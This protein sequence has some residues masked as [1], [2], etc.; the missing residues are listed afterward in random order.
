MSRETTG[1]FYASSALM[2]AYSNYMR[3]VAEEELARI[4]SDKDKIDDLLHFN[5]TM[6][7]ASFF[8]CFDNMCKIAFWSK[9]LNFNDHNKPIEDR[10]CFDVYVDATEG[11]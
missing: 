6:K 2:T 7:S 10:E 1:D 3:E 9:I 8:T 5:E 4:E 11:C